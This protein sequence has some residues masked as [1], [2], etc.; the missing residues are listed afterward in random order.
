VTKSTPTHFLETPL[1]TKVV[2]LQKLASMADCKDLIGVSPDSDTRLTNLS[3][4]EHKKLE[5]DTK[6]LDEE[7]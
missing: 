3:T 7:I 2:D 5:Y 6:E 1:E 4:D